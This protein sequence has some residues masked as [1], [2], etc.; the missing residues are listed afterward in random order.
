MSLFPGLFEC[1]DG[2]KIKRLEVPKVT[3]FGAPIVLNCDYTL[4]ASVDEGLVV[5]W[6]FNDVNTLIYQWIPN[7]KPRELGEISFS[8]FSAR[9]RKNCRFRLERRRRLEHFQ[10]TRISITCNYSDSNRSAVHK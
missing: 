8:F 2:V 1:I 9:E 3:Q 5:K 7:E 6:F 4:E 10:C